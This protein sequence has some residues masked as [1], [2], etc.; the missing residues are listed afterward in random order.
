MLKVSIL[1]P[2]AF[3][4][5]KELEISLLALEKSNLLLSIV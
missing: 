3:T 2:Q 4:F 5:P 1:L